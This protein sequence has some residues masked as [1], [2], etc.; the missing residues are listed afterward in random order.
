MYFHAVHFQ[1]TLQLQLT[2]MAVQTIHIIHF[3]N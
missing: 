1:L 2:I 3:E